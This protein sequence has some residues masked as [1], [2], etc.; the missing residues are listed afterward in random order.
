M[1]FTGEQDKE[2]CIMLFNLLTEEGLE[3]TQEILK[4]VFTRETGKFAKLLLKNLTD[5][6]EIK[7]KEVIPE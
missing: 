6:E 4:A 2:Q 3:L 5:Q 1:N 7:L